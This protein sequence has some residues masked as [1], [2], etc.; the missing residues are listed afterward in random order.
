MCLYNISWS[1]WPYC[2]FIGVCEG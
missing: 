1:N 2:L